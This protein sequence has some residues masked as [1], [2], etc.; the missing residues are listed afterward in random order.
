MPIRRPEPGTFEDLLKPA[1]VAIASLVRLTR[2][3]RTEPY[4][5]RR[6]THRFDDT[7]P[8]KPTQFGVLYAADTLEIAFAESVI[9]DSALY[10]GH[11]FK[12]SRADLTSR[13]KVYFEHPAK[14]RL[15]L[16]DLTGDNLKELGNR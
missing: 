3:P 2:F 13:K 12:V 9:H 14:R 15:E 10:D 1:K 11:Y 8:I 4:W 16:A 5:G 7:W 6:A